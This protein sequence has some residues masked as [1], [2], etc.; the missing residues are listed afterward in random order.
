[1]L[2]VAVGLTATSYIWLQT[3][4]TQ[5]F[6]GIEEQQESGQRASGSQITVLSTNSSNQTVTIQ[7]TGRYNVS[8]FSVYVDGSKVT[9]TA[10]ASLAPGESGDVV[11][12]A[13]SKGYHAVRIATTY[14]EAIVNFEAIGGDRTPPVTTASLSPASPNGQNSWY[15]TTVSVTLSCTDDDSGCLPSGTKYCT[16]TTN[17]C[18]PLTTYSAPF[19]VATGSASNYARFN[20]VD[21][22]GN[23]ESVKSTGPLKIDTAA[24]S[25]PTIT[26]T[27]NWLVGQPTV[28]LSWTASS[29]A[30][31]GLAGYRLYRENATSNILLTTT[32]STSYNDFGLNIGQTYTYKV[33]AYDNAGNNAV[34]A[35]KTVTTLGICN[36]TQKVIAID[37][38]NPNSI[39]VDNNYI[40][41]TDEGGNISKYSKTSGV[42][43]V[44]KNGYVSPTD[45]IADGNYL[46]FIE[47]YPMI[48]RIIRLS[49]TGSETVLANNVDSPQGLVADSTNLYFFNK[50]YGKGN[51]IWRLPKTGGSLNRVTTDNVNDI[52][53][54]VTDGTNV[55]YTGSGP[56]TDV[57]MKVPVG[58][59]SGTTILTSELAWYLDIDTNNIYWA[60]TDIGY[61]AGI[62][63]ISKSGGA[64][65]TVAIYQAN[66]DN[67]TVGGNNYVY[68]LASDS[69]YKQ[70]IGAAAC[71]DQYMGLTPICTVLATGGG[72]QQLVDMTQD[73]NCFYW[74]ETSNAIES[75][76]K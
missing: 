61:G 69:L 54:I 46:Y 74:T 59:G 21:V 50:T 30:T 34:N 47:G 60:D 18:T 9:A 41:W 22:A 67:L 2:M 65:G 25:V 15:I 5:V 57:I 71:Y 73:S 36:S 39:A 75:L 49:P 32:T 6:G 58:G 31:S 51:G 55:Y 66:P 17:T 76:A 13:M 27:L 14:T 10:P 63:N 29:D 45:L 62:Y 33:S 8:D 56:T 42:T 19:N 52:I 40:Y 28:S 53:Q 38:Y 24:P 35:T 70:R 1:L 20:S 7:N 48:N 3:T 43:T 16:D 44:I 12:P 37:N 26:A 23:A 64:N 11:L 4:Q 68:W 72:I